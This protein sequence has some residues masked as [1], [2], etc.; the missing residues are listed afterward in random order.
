MEFLCCIQSSA[1]PCAISLNWDSTQARNNFK[2]IKSIVVWTGPWLFAISSSEPRA[3]LLGTAVSQITLDVSCC[4]QAFWLL[5]L[6]SFPLLEASSLSNPVFSLFGPR[7]TACFLPSI[8]LLELGSRICHCL[9]WGCQCP[10][11]LRVAWEPPQILAP[12]F[13]QKTNLEC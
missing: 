9:H 6:Q 5:G 10:A 4:T 1:L 2:W 12:L 11:M 3:H 8:K 13:F 7:N